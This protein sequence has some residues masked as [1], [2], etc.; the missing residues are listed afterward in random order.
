M[1]PY[2]EDPLNFCLT[3]QTFVGLEFSL[4]G[5]PRMRQVNAAEC[6]FALF[7]CDGVLYVYILPDSNFLE[8]PTHLSLR[9]FP[10]LDYVHI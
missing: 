9:L 8:I 1:D 3:Q 6:C 7:L 10:S 5:R 2:I 4:H